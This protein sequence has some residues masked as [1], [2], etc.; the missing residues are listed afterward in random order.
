MVKRSS[1]SELVGGAFSRFEVTTFL[2]V[3][4]NYSLPT[5]VRGIDRYLVAALTKFPWPY[6]VSFFLETGGA[7]RYEFG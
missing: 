5:C 6:G 2:A 7:A 1:N 4:N 3:E